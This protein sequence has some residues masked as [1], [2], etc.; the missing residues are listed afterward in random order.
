MA[1]I[2]HTL[3]YVAH[4]LFKP[5][6]IHPLSISDESFGKPHLTFEIL[7]GLQVPYPVIG[8]NFISAWMSNGLRVLR[9]GLE[10][11][12]REYR[13]VWRLVFYACT[14]VAKINHWEHLRKKDWKANNKLINVCKITLLTAYA[15]NANK[16]NFGK[17]FW[18]LH[19][20]R[21]VQGVT[22]CS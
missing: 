7:I 4:F 3:S 11:Y 9:I 16:S 1:T 21:I 22:Q 15:I 14:S 20:L 5:M 12:T 17:R 13:H 8:F 6:N 18:F 2:Y 10:K 19:L